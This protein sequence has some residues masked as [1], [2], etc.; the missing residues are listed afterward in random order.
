M[1]INKDLITAHGCGFSLDAAH[2]CAL[3]LASVTRLGNDRINIWH[4]SDSPRI[5]KARSFEQKV[6]LMRFSLSRPSVRPAYQSRPND[7][8]RSMAII[9]DQSVGGDRTWITAM[10]YH[11]YIWESFWEISLLPSIN[12]NGKRNHLYMLT[13]LVK[14]NYSSYRLP[15]N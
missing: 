9:S 10:C 13:F 1:Y 5:G 3:S 7:D 11:H 6:S 15:P 2:W 4:N 12:K 8:G 14:S